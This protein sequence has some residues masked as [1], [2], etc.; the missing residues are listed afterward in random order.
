MADNWRNPLAGPGPDPTTADALANLPQPSWHDRYVKPLGSA[1]LAQQEPNWFGKNV[2]G[3]VGKMSESLP[4]GVGDAILAGLMGPRAPVRIAAPIKAYHGSP[5]DFDKFDLGKIGTGEG[6]QAYGHGLYFAEAEPAALWYRDKLGL[7]N[8]SR[9]APQGLIADALSKTPGDYKA[10][11]DYV[12]Q[13][14]ESYARRWGVSPEGAPLAKMYDDAIGILDRAVADPTFAPSSGKMYEVALH[15]APEQFLDWDKPLSGQSPIARD[16]LVAAYRDA[17]ERSGYKVS[18][19]EHVPVSEHVQ[20]LNNAMALAAQKPAEGRAD[21]FSYYNRQN[22]GQAAVSDAFRGGGL[23]GTRYK[24]QGSR[25]SEGGTS[26]YSVWSSEIIEILRKY[27][28][29]GPAVVGGGVAV[30][31]LA[32]PE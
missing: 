15:A 13:K 27:G 11:R 4:P 14:K 7:A 21:M 8:D 26:N 18:L 22:D 20:S 30:N 17:A 12:L 10:A 29:A 19:L 5:H 1:A 3:G 6:A 24:D 25:N 2:L 9:P 32:G 31:G 28:L 16:A 23:H